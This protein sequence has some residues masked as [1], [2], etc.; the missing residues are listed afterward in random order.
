V[1]SLGEIAEA[2]KKRDAEMAR[3]FLEG[4]KISGAGGG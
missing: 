3:L 2:L 1:E 4:M